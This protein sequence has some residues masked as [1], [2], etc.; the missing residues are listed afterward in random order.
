MTPSIW[1]AGWPACSL[2]IAQR[3]TRRASVRLSACAIWV[4]GCLSRGEFLSGRAQEQL[5]MMRATG[6]DHAAQLALAP[7]SQPIM[8]AKARFVNVEDMHGDLLVP[9]RESSCAAR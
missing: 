2:S 4:R 6:R 5:V 8:Q 3:I 1:N 9:D 7:E